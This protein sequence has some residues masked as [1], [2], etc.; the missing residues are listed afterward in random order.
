[1]NSLI[2][3]CSLIRSSRPSFYVHVFTRVQV[4]WV[5]QIRQSKKFISSPN[6]K[7]EVPIYLLEDVKYVGEKGKVIWV[8][9][10]LARVNLYPKKKAIP[11]RIFDPYLRGP[12]HRRLLYN[13]IGAQ[14]EQINLSPDER[15]ERS[16][17]FVQDMLEKQ[18]LRIFP[19][20]EDFVLFPEDVS[21]SFRAV[22]RMHIPRESIGE[23]LEEGKSW[24]VRGLGAFSF[25]VAI[26]PGVETI[27]RISVEDPAV[28]EEEREKGLERKRE[29]EREMAVKKRRSRRAKH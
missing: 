20:E 18:A 29:R 27:G 15:K 14:A 22:F 2:N 16:V 23:L 25:K 8:N 21:V 10:G 12:L 1:M 3:S 17:R 13:K 26:N 4:V 6:R 9:P 19:G 11:A 7:R 28:A 5:G 24:P